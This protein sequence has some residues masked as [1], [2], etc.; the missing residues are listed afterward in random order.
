MKLEAY[1]FD[2]T[3]K[4]GVHYSSTEKVGKKNYK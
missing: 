3:Q 1:R 2:T 4:W